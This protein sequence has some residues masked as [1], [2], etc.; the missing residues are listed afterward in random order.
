MYPDKTI[1]QKDTCTSVFIAVLY[2]VAKTWKQPQYSLTDECIKKM[3]SIYTME[4]YSAIKRNTFESVLVRWMNL[5]SIIQSEVS[6]KEKGKYHI[7]TH[8]YGI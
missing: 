1:I 6:Q 5:E 2:T 3:W 7:L 8:I 4:Y